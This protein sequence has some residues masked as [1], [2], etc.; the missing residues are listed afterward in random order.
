MQR[1]GG[2]K[3]LQ[4]TLTTKLKEKYMKQLI[5]NITALTLFVI[6][7]MDICTKFCIQFDFQV[8]EFQFKPLHFLLASF[9]FFVHL[10]LTLLDVLFS[11]FL[12]EMKKHFPYVN[13]Y[14]NGFI[15]QHQ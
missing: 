14:R 11:F 9:E 5:L 10:L 3:V 6:L 1:M 7:K 2:V 8:L 4:T 15:I 12:S 13:R